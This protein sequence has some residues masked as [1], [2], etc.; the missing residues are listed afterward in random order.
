FSNHF[1]GAARPAAA[2]DR[3]RQSID[4]HD[5]RNETSARA[6]GLRFPAQHLA[7]GRSAGWRDFAAPRGTGAGSRRHGFERK[8]AR[9]AA[10]PIGASLSAALSPEVAYP[11]A[12]AR[13]G[14]DL[15]R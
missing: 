8:A 5:V 4:R 13:R 11:D 3:L 2:E 15:V 12:F 9:R 10:K 14:A 6:A 7:Y 1:P